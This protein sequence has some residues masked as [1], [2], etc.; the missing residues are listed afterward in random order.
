M[1]LQRVGHDCTS[2]H[3][4]GGDDG[5]LSWGYRPGNERFTTGVMSAPSRRTGPIRTQEG[6]PVP[7]W[8]KGELSE[9][10]DGLADTE[11]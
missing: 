9:G 8:E 5:E 7:S 11:G 1:G 10:I 4:L 3:K 2:L 6:H